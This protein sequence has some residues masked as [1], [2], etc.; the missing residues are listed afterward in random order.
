MKNIIWIIL[1]ILIVLVSLFSSSKVSAE[2]NYYLIIVSEIEQKAKVVDKSSSM[3]SC[4]E[5]TERIISDFFTFLKENQ[6][7]I[8][9]CCVNEAQTKHSCLDLSKS[10]ILEGKGL[11]KEI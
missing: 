8:K 11:R 9:F 4:Q 7:K 2:E 6:K 3:K 10:K 5:N 1:F